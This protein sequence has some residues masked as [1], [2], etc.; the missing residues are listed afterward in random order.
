LQH[1]AW[2]WQ[3]LESTVPTGISLGC[4]KAAAWH[5]FDA[6]GFLLFGLPFLAV[7]LY[8]AATAYL[9]RQT[10]VVNGDGIT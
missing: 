9:K 1:W 5:P 4:A 6:R 10:L 2:K 3:A 7:S 8:R